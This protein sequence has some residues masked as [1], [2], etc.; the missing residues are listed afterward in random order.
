MKSP[1]GVVGFKR[2]ALEPTTWAALS[3]TLS[4]ADKRSAVSSSAVRAAA[5]ATGSVDCG[6]WLLI[7]E[8]TPTR[9]NSFANSNWRTLIRTGP[10]GGGGV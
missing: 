8:S 7:L 5:A 9:L 3:N 6:T 4:S 2:R 1:N 10:L